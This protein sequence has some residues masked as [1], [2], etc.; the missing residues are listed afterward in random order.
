MCYARHQNAHL[1][2]VNCAFSGIASLENPL[3]IQFLNLKGR[4]AL[5][6]NGLNKII[7]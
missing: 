5:K 1:R 3:M 7:L 4:M 2:K 6:I